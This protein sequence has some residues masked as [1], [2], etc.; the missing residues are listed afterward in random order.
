M[1]QGLLDYLQ[2]IGIFLVILFVIITSLVVGSRWI[3]NR[4][5]KYLKPRARDLAIVLNISSLELLTTWGFVYISGWRFIDVLFMMSLMLLSVMW[6]S[7]VFKSSFDNYT[8][9]EAKE[10]P[11]VDAKQ[12]VTVSRF[13]LTP[14]KSGTL[15]FGITGFITS[16]IMYMPYF[17][18]L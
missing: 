5:L 10:L 2:G 14:A 7:A 16:F 9:A 18:N 17:I 6:V 12:Q 4:I 8:R 1:L 13:T 3:E 15:L 11:G